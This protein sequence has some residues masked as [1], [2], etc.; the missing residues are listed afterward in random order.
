MT[1]RDQSQIAKGLRLRHGDSL[2]RRIRERD[3]ISRGDELEQVLRLAEQF[4]VHVPRRMEYPRLA[5][6]APPD[7]GD[8]R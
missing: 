5:R 1:Q 3:R 6:L 7:P 2:D 4:P 8:L